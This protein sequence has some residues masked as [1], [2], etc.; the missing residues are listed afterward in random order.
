MIA[1]S[2]ACMAGA[3]LTVLAVLLSV[4]PAFAADAVGWGPADNGLRISASLSRPNSRELR[5]T[6][7]NLGTK[8]ILIPLGVKVGN[9]HLI[10][11][12]LFLKTANGEN[13]KVIYTGLGVIAG[14]VEPLT[15]GLRARE[16]YTV[17]L[18]TGRYYVPDLS[19]NLAAFVERTRCELW[20]ELDVQ[21]DQCPDPT[22]LD[23]LRRTLPCWHG[24]VAS[25]VLQVGGGRAASIAR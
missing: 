9:P 19:E 25:N 5:V 3:R 16:M 18:A 15:M 7:E 12:N 24:S 10:L 11:F 20:V 17:L 14:A 4:L 21:V 1:V 23:P 6:L 8:D 22:T 13:R 2:N